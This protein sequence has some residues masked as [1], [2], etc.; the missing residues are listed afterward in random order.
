MLR[1]WL[2]PLSIL[3]GIYLSLFALTYA[4]DA[5][6]SADPW[7]VLSLVLHPNPQ[8]AANTLANAGEIVAAVLAIALTVVAIIVELASNRYTHRVTELFVGER[9]NFVVMGLFVVTALQGMW[10]TMTFD[11][12]GTGHGFVPYTG[13]A[14]SMGLLTLC[15]LI[16]L[17]YFNFVFSYLNPLQI[18]RRIRLHT[19]EQMSKQRTVEQ[20][21]RAKG[22]AVRGVEQL[23]DVALNA[24][25]HRDKAV[26]I[27]SVE[28]LSRLLSDYQGVRE[29]LPDSWFE[30]D[31]ALASN[32]DFVSMDPQTLNRLTEQR[33]WLEMKVM[34][35]YQMVFGEAINR[36]R[37]L[38]YVIAINTRTLAEQAAADSNYDLL[39]LLMK[40]FNSYL[41]AAV[42]AKDV[43]TAYNVLHQYRRLA[44]WLL[45][46]G[47]DSRAIEIIGYFKY[48]GGL[49][50]HAR[51]PF[52]LETVAYD[53]CAVLEQAASKSSPALDE[54]LG[55]FLRVDKESE[56]E[57]QE[58]SLRGV[59][60]AQIK[61]ATLF[62][63]TGDHGRARRVYEDLANEDPMRL[64]SI[65]EELDAVGSSEYWEITD[66]GA[67][68]EYI[69]THRRE[70]MALFF[71]WF[72]DLP[73][74][75][76]LV[77]EHH[78][79]PPG[80]GAVPA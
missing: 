34:R 19:F 64:V 4:L 75:L 66:R 17:P 27:A 24:M 29:G 49:A 68:F 69:P 78:P 80:G 6:S 70:A 74:P 65:R 37:D 57:V 1:I 45:D 48:Y 2:L 10:V 15:L 41:R 53:V 61:L 35:Q 11:N 32:P 9:V 42:N 55:I 13:I 50:F 22:E 30:V 51:L 40:F 39:N 16:L 8:A 23:S 71:S 76:G 5:V 21:V 62:L 12:S 14:V 46:Q 73:V 20:T 63:F 31:D 7:H 38:N 36:M 47:H 43:R 60:K 67:N 26:S 33:L 25:E 3:G 77:S 54:L 59:R 56:G 52:L 44:E 72:D 79:K 58:A 28:A 18:V